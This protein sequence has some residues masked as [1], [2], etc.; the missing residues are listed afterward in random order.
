MIE[1]HQFPRALGLPNMSP[2][3]MK[4]EAYLRLTGLPYRH[5]DLFDPRKAPKGKGPYIVDGGETICDSNF[6]LDYLKKKYG[7]PLGEGLSARERARHHALTRMLEEHTYFIGVVDRWLEPEN[8]VRVRE[9]WF[10]RVPAPFRGLVFAMVQR[11]IRRTVWGHGIYRHSHDE[12]MQLLAKDLQALADTLGDEP[13]FGGDTPR[14]IDTVIFS[15]IANMLTNA[16]T[17]RARELAASHLGLVDYN[18]RMGQKV[19][20]DFFPAEQGAAS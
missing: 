19:F 14:E 12:R 9:L 4:V 8:A 16:V 20:P 7:D 11:S 3:C 15:F 10:R 2:F 6:I 17:G 13:F 18:A 5:V 1:L